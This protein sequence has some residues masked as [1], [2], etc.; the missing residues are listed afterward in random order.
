MGSILENKIF[1]N[2]YKAY[3]SDELYEFLY[4]EGN[5]KLDF[6]DSYSDHNDMYTM[7]FWINKFLQKNVNLNFD[8]FL[9]E[10]LVNMMNTNNIVKVLVVLDFILTYAQIKK[11]HEIIF[12]INIDVLIPL[13]KDKLMLLKQ[14]VSEQK[15]QS[16][17]SSCNLYEIKTGNKIL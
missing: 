15:W 9:T 4:G 10:S 12:K 6:K 8:N 1:N 5:Y 3:Q 7:Q 13:L 11:E 2:L 17:Q 14:Q 16:I